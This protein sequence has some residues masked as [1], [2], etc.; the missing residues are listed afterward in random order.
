MFTRVYQHMCQDSIKGMP[1]CPVQGFSA[2]SAR[3][4]SALYQVRIDDKCDFQGLLAKP[5]VAC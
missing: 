2:S 5:V 1:W 3:A 4:K